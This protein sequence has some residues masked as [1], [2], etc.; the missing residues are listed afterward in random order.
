MIRYFPIKPIYLAFLLVLVYYLIFTG[1]PA[2]LILFLFTLYQLWR[3]HD[4][5]IFLQVICILSCFALISYV[6]QYK[7]NQDYR[8]SP[9]QVKQLEVIPDSLSVNGDQ[10]SF[11]AKNHGRTYQV[12]Y[13]LKSRREKIFYKT[14]T[15]KLLMSVSAEV[16]EADEQRN[17]HGFNYRS[18]L[19]NKGIYRVVTI[20]KVTALQ[21]D[22]KLT[23]YD[24]LHIWRRKALVHCLTN[25]SS[26]MN[27]YMTGL[28]F[29]YL[30]KDFD[31]M[32]DL[33]TSLGI[34]HLFALSGMQV[35]FFIKIFRWCF[36]RL[37]LRR[38]WVDILQVPFSVIYAGMTGFAVSVIRSLI[39]SSL[40]Q[41]GLRRLDNIAL[42][43]FIMFM[44]MPNFL[45]TA[46]G[47][48]SFTYAFILAVIDIEHYAGLKKLLLET[49]SV[50]LGVLPV[51]IYL[52]G[53]FQPLSIL[54]TAGFSL[55]FDLMILP[56]LSLLFLISP[57][58]KLDW[59]NPVFIL[60]E[61]VIAWTHNLI[62]NPPVFGSPD[63]CL[64][65]ILLVCLAF[66]YDYWKHRLLRYSLLVSLVILFALIKHPLDNE[67]TI[68]DVGQGDSIF[69]RDSWGKNILIDVGGKVTFGNHEEWQ[70]ENTTSNAEKTLIPYLKSRGVGEINQLVLTH[71]DTDHMGDMEE[72]AKAFRIGEV[73]VSSGSL[74]KPSF[75][76]RLKKM[77]VKVRILQAEDSLPIMGSQ[78]RV[79]Y[80]NQV[81]D[82]GNND[83]LVLYGQ[84]L[85]KSFLFTGDLEAQ[86]EEDLM[87]LYPELQVDILK[88]G[89]HGS[90]GSSN[91]LFLKQLQADTA[92]I[93]AGKGN[94]YGHPNEE[95][96]DRFAVE[97]MRV[98][99]T[100]QQGAIR[101]HGFWKWSVETVR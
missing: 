5:Q 73:L 76:S 93:S 10:L 45:L 43:I 52:F 72:V 30:D 54:L 29:G 7:I 53:V 36:L 32:N 2:V 84:L 67:V 99:R 28:L 56:L 51:L 83:S 85:N 42:T 74:T 79:L 100:D 27:H 68:V 63:V 81:G 3:H 64:L 39:Q 22:H 6:Y 21:S 87:Q 82:G 65:L 44:L 1:Y 46:G 14:V 91:P 4:Y 19:K 55:I 23:L 33:Y 40:S 11:Q 97:K 89:H 15:E 35:G 98:Y 24:Y 95:T 26:P 12:F 94:R 41:L 34:I 60:L 16:E 90:K 59:V 61:R 70:K 9:E 25:F 96:L 78:L 8:N 101:Y 62:G 57:F 20:D 86:G 31:R 38:D 77:K 13:R 92:L 80:P 88:A 18:Y 71:T 47:T 49:A 37:G 69:L 66:L 48:L 75:V 17:F 50:S 58:M